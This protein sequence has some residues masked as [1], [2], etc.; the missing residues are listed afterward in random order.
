MILKCGKPL[1]NF[2]FNFNLRQYN[3]GAL[4]AHVAAHGGRAPGTVLDVGC[5]VG[6]STR[7]LSE[8]FPAAQ[9]TGR[10]LSP[11]MLAVAAHRDAGQAG[12]ERRRWVHGLGEDTGMADGSVVGVTLVHLSPQRKHCVWGKLVGW[13][14]SV[15]Q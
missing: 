9:V 13:V 10:D 12:A 4:R 11:Y 3:T 2:A 14:A 8:A 5:G 15:C 6:I 1:P 7:F